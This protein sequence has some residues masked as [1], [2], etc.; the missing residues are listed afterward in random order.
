[1]WSDAFLDALQ[2]DVAPI[3]LLESVQVGDFSGGRDLRIS[4]H[5]V[6]GYEE[7]IDPPRC[8]V[9]HGELQAPSWTRTGTAYTIA[10][11][12][13]LRRKVRPGQVLRLR[14]GFRSWSPGEYQP[15]F[16][17][18]V[19]GLRWTAGR[20]MLSLVDLAY[21][22]HSRFVSQTADPRLFA[23]L[24]A[25]A[26]VSSA[27]TASD[28][29]INV[30]STSDFVVSDVDPYLLLV[31]PDG[32]EAPFFVT[33]SGKTGTTFTGCSPGQFGTLAVSCGTASTIT[34]CAYS[35]AHPLNIVRRILVSTG[36]PNAHGSRDVFPASWGYGFPTELVDGQDINAFVAASNPASGSNNWEFVQTEPADDGQSVITEFLR[37]GGFFLGEHQGQITARAVCDPSTVEVPNTWELADGTVEAYDAWDPSVIESRTLQMTMGS[38]GT[39]ATSATE[40]LDTRPC[41]EKLVIDQPSIWDNE[42]AWGSSIDDRL[43]PYLLRRGE[44]L[45]LRSAG[46]RL[47]P[48]A[49]GD[50]LRLTTD[51]V[52]SR[53]EVEGNAFRKRRTLVVGGGPDWFR[54]E[55]RYTL[56]STVPGALVTQ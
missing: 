13:D 31:T 34:P 38:G 30:D 16:V 2:G 47:A 10:S 5:Y 17:G 39:W 14:M 22:L 24:E 42:T 45:T 19:R 36:T 25:S 21:S 29:T 54:G 26:L 6:S 3:F 33:A 55:C 56:L 1:V 32:G 8:S 11:T 20:W 40:Q 15:V 35:Q 12:K 51:Q 7:A 9:S 18:A 48:A 52:T 46:L 41:R 44:R 27:Y 23:S 49:I 43:R 53:Y 28:T 50:C 37:P 4:S